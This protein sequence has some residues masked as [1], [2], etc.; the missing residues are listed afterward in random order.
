MTLRLRFGFQNNSPCSKKP[1]FNVHFI[2]SEAPP[3]WMAAPGVE[4]H[5]GLMPG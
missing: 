2:S 3:S 5:N 1:G 4:S